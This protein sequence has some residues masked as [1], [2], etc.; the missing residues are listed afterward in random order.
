MTHPTGRPGGGIAD[1]E[2]AVLLGIGILGFGAAVAAAVTWRAKT[3]LWLLEHQVLVTADQHPL[4]TLPY[5]AGAGLDMPRLA[6]AAA[7]TMLLLL[8]SVGLVQRCVR[9]GG[10]Q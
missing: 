6:L 4:I 10:P 7:A 3:L 5:T 2:L 1:D 8:A 9:R